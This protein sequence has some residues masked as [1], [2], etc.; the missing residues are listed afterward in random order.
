MASKVRFPLLH[1]A[2]IRTQIVILAECEKK[3]HEA[4]RRAEEALT[5]SST[6]DERFLLLEVTGRQLTYAARWDEGVKWLQDALALRA[7]GFP[8]WE[9]NVL[10]TLSEG[11]GRL[12][13]NDATNYTAKAVEVAEKWIL[14]PMQTAEALAEHSI[15]L[16]FASDRVGALHALEKG[17]EILMTRELAAAL[18]KKTFLLFLHVAGYFGAMAFSGSPPASSFETPRRGM[19]LATDNISEELY[20]PVQQIATFYQNGDVR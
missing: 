11:I 20:K 2:A 19:F 7:T 4:V 18:W 8:I 1:A 9:R 15:A 10:I 14:E 12:N 16:W 13:V 6:D 3:I 5:E 17:V